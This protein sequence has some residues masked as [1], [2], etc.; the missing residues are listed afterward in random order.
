MITTMHDPLP[1]SP[2][3]RHWSCSPMFLAHHARIATRAEHPFDKAVIAYVGYD[4]TGRW[5]QIFIRASGRVSGNTE[6]YVG[7]RGGSI[8]VPRDIAEALWRTTPGR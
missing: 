6:K 2:R 8:Q 4:Q 5:W 3:V 1:A 7:G